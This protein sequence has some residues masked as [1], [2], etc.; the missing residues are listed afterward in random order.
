MLITLFR[1]SYLP[2]YLFLLLIGGI[3]WLPAF[4]SPPEITVT[5][6]SVQ[7]VHNLVSRWLQHL[8][9]IAVVI[10]FVLL[11]LEA[12]FFNMILISHDLV[13]KNSMVPA[14]VYTVLMSSHYENLTL[15]PILLAGILLLALL[16]V[17]FSMYEKADTLKDQLTA[18]FL[19]AFA[20]MVYFPSVFFIL[21]ILYVL[22]IYRIVTWREWLVPFIGLVIPYLYLWVWYF[23]AGSLPGVYSE[24]REFFTNLFITRVRP[25]TGDMIVEGALVLLL[26]V[27]AFYKVLSQLNSYN[28]VMRKNLSVGNWLLVVCLI[29]TFTSGSLLHNNLYAFGGSVVLAHY[30]DNARKP[31]WNEI[32]FFIFAAGITVNNFL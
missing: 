32:V 31:V 19:I 11:M 13:S 22:I 28:I 27:P 9:L 21:F 15:T 6:H 20:S 8:P 1:S 7:P 14:I 26:L 5:A 29:I 12:L 23:W 24:Y 2:Q 3:L 18:G 10:G 25:D 4:L 17:V 30:L 16:N